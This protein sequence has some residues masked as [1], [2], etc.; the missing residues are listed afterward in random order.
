[1]QQTW[2]DFLQEHGAIFSEDTVQHF[3]NI[4]AEF[5]SL[6]EENCL[7]DLSHIGLLSVQGPDAKSFLQG[8]VTCNL[9]EVSLRQSRLGANCNQ[10]GRTQ[11]IFRILQAKD[12]PVPEYYLVM[13]KALVLTAAQHLLKF[14]LFSDVQIHEKSANVVRIGLY[15]PKADHYLAKIVGEQATLLNP[16]DVIQE[17]NLNFCLISRIPGYH[18]RYE[19]FGNLESIKALWT[20]LQSCFKPVSGLVWELLDIQAGLP[21]IYPQTIDLILPHYANLATL[22]GISFN[23]GCYLG[24]EVIAR[25]HYRGKIKKHMY[26]AFLAQGAQPEPGDP[27]FASDNAESQGQVVRCSPLYHEEGHELLVILNDELS[28][29]EGVHLHEPGG[30]LLQRLE[31]PYVP[32]VK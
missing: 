21:T 27:L 26:R 20:Q 16:Y 14:A 23:K 7:V 13:P 1:M 31:L 24:Q 22:N 2:K 29:F 12:D 11:S 6:D 18:P 10:K 9:E 17:A 32:A 8:Q 15:G 28:S 4:Q 19:I 5:A 25:M 30:P 3:G